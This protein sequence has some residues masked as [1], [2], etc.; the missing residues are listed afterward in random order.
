MNAS[1]WGNADWVE[2]HVLPLVL[3]FAAGTLL[4]LVSQDQH[5]VDQRDEAHAVAV[6]A[7]RIATEANNVARRWEAACT[8]LLSL[9][10]ESTPEIIPAAAHMG[11]VAR[12]VQP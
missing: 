9:P 11:R 3:A 1:L 8:P 5:L 10:V 7:R 4:G 6:R 12:E 2:R